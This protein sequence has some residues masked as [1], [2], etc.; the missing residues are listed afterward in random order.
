MHRPQYNVVF[1]RKTAL[2]VLGYRVS[3]DTL[4]L[5]YYHTQST[6]RLIKY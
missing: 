1:M 6:G 3:T 5:L 4:P 2:H